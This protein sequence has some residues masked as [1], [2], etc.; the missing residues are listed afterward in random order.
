MST[1]LTT[2]ELDAALA[3]Y[4]GEIIPADALSVMD[5]ET[6]AL[7]ASGIERRA[8]KP[9]AQGRCVRLQSLLRQVQSFLS[10][11]EAAGAPIAICTCKAFNELCRSFSNLRRKS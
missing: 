2:Q 9:G 5:A 6:E 8:L 3:K 11:T 7:R 1:H 4:R 10:F